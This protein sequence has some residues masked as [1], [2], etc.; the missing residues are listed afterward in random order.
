MC[1]CV[2]DDD[3]DIDLDLDVNVNV[4]VNVN[5]NVDE[6]MKAM[7]TLCF[8]IEKNLT[9]YTLNSIFKIE[10][11][12]SLNCTEIESGGVKIESIHILI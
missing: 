10:F 3:N 7:L 4:N 6:R 2:C 12:D 9:A 5:P 1:V 11:C 8:P